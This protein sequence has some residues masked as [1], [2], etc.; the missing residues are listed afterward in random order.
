M[1]C[2]AW[3]VNNRVCCTNAYKKQPRVVAEHLYI[4]CSY[5]DNRHRASIIWQS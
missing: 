2:E 4:L 1:P 3:R 5:V